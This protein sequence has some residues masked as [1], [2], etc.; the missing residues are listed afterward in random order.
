M[1]V[2]NSRRGIRRTMNNAGMSMLFLSFLTSVFGT[3]YGDPQITNLAMGVGVLF[4][5]LAV[6]AL[7]LARA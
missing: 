7:L 1:E 2:R 3:A 6:F 4:A 5:I